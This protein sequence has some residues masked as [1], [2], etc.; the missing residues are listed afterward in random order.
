MNKVTARLRRMPVILRPGA[1]AGL[2]R[3]LLTMDYVLPL[4]LRRSRSDTLRL[5]A[6]SG[7]AEGTLHFGHPSFAIDR[8]AYFGIF[9]DRWYDADYRGAVVVDV[10]AHKGYYGAYALLEGAAEIRSF[11]PEPENFALLEKTAVSFDKPW[12]THP[13]AVG[14]ATGRALLHV[15][16]ESASHSLVRSEASG[17]RETIRSE[18]VAVV[19]MEDVLADASRSESPIIVKIDA[20]GA[21]CDIVLGTPLDAWQ[22]VEHVFL[23][24]HDFATCS[25][26]AIVEHLERAGLRQT[27]HVLDDGA[28]LVHLE[29]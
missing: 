15:S 21:E 27:R 17:S 25:T 5:H 19:A 9:L 29:R 8:V 3:E 18:S 12:L 26:A 14:S 11:E 24:V 7:R 16:A 10:G 2:R 6:R 4:R 20:E 22:P 28:E 13:A 1:R 23:E